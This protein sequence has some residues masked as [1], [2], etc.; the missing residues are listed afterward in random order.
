[1]R[2]L[3]IYLFVIPLSIC[4]QNGTT[5]TPFFNY[6]YDEFT[7]KVYLEVSALDT[8]FLYIS[9]LAGGIGSND[10]GLDR[11][12]IDDTRIVKFIKRGNKLLLIQPNQK[13][14]A[15]S[16]NLQEVNAEQQ[17]YASYV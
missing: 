2:L 11:G 7:G 3:Y 12:K 1:M 17:A 9:A 6:Q 4:A 13:Y 8:E 16:D 15:D 14:R 5:D 10:I